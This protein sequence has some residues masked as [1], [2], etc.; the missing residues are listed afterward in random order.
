MYSLQSSAAL[1]PIIKLLIQL[2][3][4]L[5]DHKYSFKAHF[6]LLDQTQTLLVCLNHSACLG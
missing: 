6:E 4:E 3:S 1:P 2:L 5:N